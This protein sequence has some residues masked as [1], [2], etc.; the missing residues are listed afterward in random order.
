M[1]YESSAS[2]N[3]LTFSVLEVSISAHPVIN[4]TPERSHRL[5]PIC[6][7]VEESHPP[8]F[9]VRERR[10][11]SSGHARHTE[12][13]GVLVGALALWRKEESGS[14]CVA[15]FDNPGHHL[16]RFDGGVSHVGRGFRSAENSDI[17]Y[18]RLSQNS[19]DP[20]PK[21]LGR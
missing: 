6:G 11:E 5:D 17:L 7:A 13:E 21:L 1:G 3:L 14:G 20:D 19:D 2:P 4:C 15:G 8:R 12:L 18:V 16:A 10:R 9:T